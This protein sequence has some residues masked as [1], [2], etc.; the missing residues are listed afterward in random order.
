MKRFCFVF[1]LLLAATCALAYVP[2][3][4]DVLCDVYDAVGLFAPDDTD[5]A[6]EHVTMISLY[7]GSAASLPN[8]ICTL[9]A[10]SYLEVVD[11]G[12]TR[13]PANM[14]N[15]TRLSFLSL[16]GNRLSDLPASMANLVNLSLLDLARN[17]FE[18]LPNE[19]CSLTSLSYLDMR[20]NNL[21]RL[22]DGASML[23]NVGYV[24]LNA[25]RLLLTELLKALPEDKAREQLTTQRIP[26]ANP[27]SSTD[28]ADVSLENMIVFE[29]LSDCVYA[30]CGDS[31]WGIKVKG[32]RGAAGKINLKGKIYTDNSGERY[33]AAE[34]YATVDAGAVAK[35]V[36]M[37]NAC[38]GGG[39]FGNQK[40]VSGGEGVNTVGGYVRTTG[41]VTGS[42]SGFFTIDDGSGNPVRVES[43][44]SIPAGFH[45][46]VTGA[47]SLRVEGGKILPVLLAKEVV[48]PR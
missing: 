8:S 37:K 15:L 22:P 10:L 25:N 16:S 47:V 40:G 6:S 4:Y 44:L 48:L 5:D 12:L 9:P 3:E 33:I 17:D 46:A 42:G 28:G 27:K 13:L 43:N 19:I 35:P 24:N 23:K 41:K 2:W 26:G 18:E 14:G 1:A 38:L 30:V 29:S 7:G 31:V 45:V 21:F 36:Y 39:D 20:E 34:S 32:L 11:C